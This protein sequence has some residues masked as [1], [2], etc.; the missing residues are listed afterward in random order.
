MSGQCNANRAQQSFRSGVAHKLSQD[1]CQTEEYCSYQVRRRVTAHQAYGEFSNQLASAAGVHSCCN[2]NHACKQEDSNP[3][4][5]VIGLFFSDAACQYAQYRSDNSSQFQRNDAGCHRTNNANHDDTAD[6]LFFR[7]S[8]GSINLLLYIC[9]LFGFS[10]RQDVFAKE[11]H[12]ND[13]GNSNRNT[14]VGIFKEAKLQLRHTSC[15]QSNVC[16]NVRRGTDQG[17][18]T[19]KAGSESQWH[20]LTGSGK[21]CLCADTHNY[22]NQASGGTGVRQERRHNSC[23]NHKTKHQ[24]VF[25]GTKQLYY[26]AA[27]LLSEAGVKHSSANDEHTAKK[28]YSRICQAKE[29]LVLRNQA[30]CTAGYSSQNRGHCQ[31]NHFGNE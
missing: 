9:N 17:A 15:F 18:G 5:G 14:D 16:Q 12:V 23:N 8:V 24:A 22:R 13:A 27:N 26:S 7:S 25:I 21:L 11:H 4:D 2:R 31:R 20:Q 29:D 19:A 28:N 30:Q 10:F 1:N 3:V 6:H